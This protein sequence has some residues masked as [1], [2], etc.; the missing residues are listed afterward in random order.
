MKDE[1][2]VLGAGPYGLAAAAHL[3]AAG[4]AVRVFGEPMEFWERHMP[5]GMLL[6]SSL[7]ASQIADPLG[8]LTLRCF[9]G[10]Q[11][12]A[13]TSP[14]PLKTFLAYAH[15]YQAH[16]VQ[17]L[18]R[19]RVERIDRVDSAFELHLEGGERR[20]CPRVVVA[21]GI[22]RFAYVPPEFAGIPPRLASH[23]SAHA[24]LARFSGR[25]VVVVGGGQSAVET[26][27][28]LAEAGAEA[29]LLHRGPAIRWLGRGHWLRKRHPAV[30]RLFYPPTDVGPPVLNQIVARPDLF[31]RLPRPLQT[32]VAC[33][34]IRP[35][36]AGWLRPRV[37]AVRI[38]AGRR[39]ISAAAAGTEIRLELGDGTG[40]T[41]DHVILATGYCLDLARLDFLA[42]ALLSAVE[43]AAGYP[44]LRT[45]FESS[46]PRLYFLGAA[47][48]WTFGPLM[49]FVSGTGYAA[50]ALTRR[51]ERCAD[52]A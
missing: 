44:R 28:L 10:A 30:R 7:E 48:A 50:R 36:A 4:L 8:A 47:A 9:E 6:R 1:V 39:V 33:R 12:G 23:S 3:R 26:A 32:R 20:R 46:V 16:A 11:G 21:T 17:D 51:V 25:R 14:L 19:R 34:S 31:R 41:V 15:W 5:A 35:A 45:G 18:D 38:T 22:G 40:R 37:S 43:R 24:D 27:A 2:A 42:P 13:C 49:R 29:E 52:P